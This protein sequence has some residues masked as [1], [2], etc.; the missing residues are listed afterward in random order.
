MVTLELH[1][2]AEQNTDVICKSLLQQEYKQSLIS[3]L[4]TFCFSV[5]KQT[6]RTVVARAAIHKKSSK[7]FISNGKFYCF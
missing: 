2:I 5:F 3:A 4:P 7:N 6:D 1:K